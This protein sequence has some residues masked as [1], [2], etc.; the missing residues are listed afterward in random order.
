M[1]CSSHG[2]HGQAA[3]PEVIAPNT[4]EVGHLYGTLA[5]AGTRSDLALPTPTHIRGR[6]ERPLLSCFRQAC[7]TGS[8]KGSKRGKVPKA[9]CSG[10][11]PTLNKGGGRDESRNRTKYTYDGD[12]KRLMRPNGTLCWIGTGCDALLE[13]D[14]SG[15]PTADHLGSTELVTNAIGG[16]RARKR[17]PDYLPYGNEL[18]FPVRN[19]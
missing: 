19:R 4:Y 18:Q 5:K 11:A 9:R 6:G 10:S 14:L 7:R 2:C 1:H 16:D 8:S 17:L 12:G 13:T 3:Q 15:N